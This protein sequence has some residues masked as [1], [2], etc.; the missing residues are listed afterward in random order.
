MLMQN[1]CTRAGGLLD[2]AANAAISKV[3]PFL[4]GLA[5]LIDGKTFLNIGSLGG[6]Q[7]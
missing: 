1:S 3:E 6:N 5:I 2:R 4:D 7:H